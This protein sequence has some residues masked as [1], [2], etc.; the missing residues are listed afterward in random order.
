MN[1]NETLREQMWDLCYGLLTA[2][3]VAALHKQIKSD[4]AAARLYAEVRLQADLVASAAKVE[5][6]SVSLSVPDDGRKVQ[7]ATKSHAEPGK[8]SAHSA[9]SS[10]SGKKSFPIPSYRT[11]N[12]LAALAATALIALIGYGLYAPTQFMASSPPDSI[13]A[14]VY[15]RQPMQSGLSQ[16]LKVV[17]TNGRGEPVSAA[18]SYDVM[19]DGSV[20]LRDEVQTD[21]SGEAQLSLLGSAVQP[22][23]V[24]EV[25]AQSDK[26]A[27]FA[28]KKYAEETDRDNLQWAETSP[29]VV[30]QLAAKPEPVTRNVQ[31]EQE[32]YQPGETFRFWV[33][34]WGTFSNQPAVPAD[35]YKL[36]AQNGREIQPAVIELRPEAGIVTGEFPIPADATAGYYTLVGVNRQSGTAVDV[37]RVAVGLDSEMSGIRARRAGMANHNRHLYMMGQIDSLAKAEA[38]DEETKK[39]DMAS[40]LAK[41]EKTEMARSGGATAATPAGPPLPAPA[42]APAGYAAKAPA[43]PAGA[44]VAGVPLRMQ[45]EL[46][47]GEAGL[48]GNHR[49]SEQLEKTVESK[50]EALFVQVPAELANLDLLVVV[51]QASV[52]VATQQ[53][54]GFTPNDD[55]AAEA[56][57]LE[58]RA[59]KNSPE[60]A[61]GTNGVA[62]NKQL[63]MTRSQL[64]LTLPPEASGELDVTLYDQSVQP[65]KPVYRQLVRRA[66]SREMNIDIRQEATVFSPQQELNVTLIAMDQNGN[67]VPRSNFSA[68]IVKAEA[69][70]AVD[71]LAVGPAPAGRFAANEE[72]AAR[73]KDGE[74]PAPGVAGGIGGG[75]GFGGG[76]GVAAK[77]ADTKEGKKD[78]AQK[79]EELVRESLERESKFKK[80]QSGSDKPAEL[81]AKQEPPSLAGPGG[82][83]KESDKTP[84]AP[85]DPQDR[86][87]EEDRAA[88]DEYESFSY[89]NSAALA[90]QAALPEEILLGSNDAIIH[91]AAQAEETAAA[92]AKVNFR[93]MIGRLVLMVA[94]AALL[95]F[96]LLAMLHRPAQAKVWVPAM[97]VVAGSFAVG[98]VWLLGGGSARRQAAKTVALA[99]DVRVSGIDSPREF[100][101]MARA[102]EASPPSAALDAP[103]ENSTVESVAETEKVPAVFSEAA[104]PMAGGRPGAFPPPVPMSAAP[105]KPALGASR[106]NEPAPDGPKS[107]AIEDRKKQG[108]Q[109]SKSDSSRGESAKDAVESK[110]SGGAQS[111]ANP[112][113]AKPAAAKS[114]LADSQRDKRARSAGLL[115]QPILPTNEKG[116]AEL[117]I[118][119][120]A[121]EGDYYLLVDVQGPNG[122]GT[123]QK[124]I[125]I[126]VPAAPAAP[127]KP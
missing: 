27:R 106:P 82:L 32:S 63:V 61:E 66:S 83:R 71:A 5:D 86:L 91:Q 52:P 98:S 73:G 36:V 38:A 80:A 97:V 28:Q 77:L 102:G 8:T 59:T 72:G 21:E 24:L 6:E 113:P 112:S 34:A 65:P 33:H 67:A 51:R 60:L 7:P 31:L 115:W 17:T 126:R 30:V 121:E 62:E 54:K 114:V 41:K 16:S 124:R 75:G 57:L 127:T 123:V 110:A 4:P 69:A 40:T 125:P 42:E 64:S 20:V 81:A 55:Q 74:V 78:N 53:Y 109:D 88:R 14:S 9:K 46:D 13:V 26:S 100:R 96:G 85:F 116:E 45:G 108:D 68:R 90:E 103:S 12:W 11:A 19:H 56:K 1:E 37:D 3:E 119:L 120:P 23:A 49:F 76:K 25:Q 92:V 44:P 15:A 122:V 50:P 79:N 87:L 2:D 47:Q 105:P 22:G 84:A 58:S 95:L 94:A 43:P 10:R 48:S 89:F 29:K 18:V 111:P 118:Q 93:Q 70:N 39:S 99:R 35:D 101:P 104:G 117:N 107:R